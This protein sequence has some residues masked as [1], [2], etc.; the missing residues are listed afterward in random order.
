MEKGSTPVL[1]FLLPYRQR[2]DRMVSTM[3]FV[4][5]CDEQGKKVAL[6][7]AQG[8]GLYVVFRKNGIV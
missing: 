7:I 2:P 3:L 1:P 8:L 4:Q 6:L 5:R